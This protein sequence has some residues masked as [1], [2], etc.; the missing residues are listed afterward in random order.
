MVHMSQRDGTQHPAAATGLNK[1]ARLVP[2]K[3][4]PRMRQ[5]VSRHV[6]RRGA[7][8]HALRYCQQNPGK[9]RGLASMGNV[10]D[11]VKPVTSALQTL[12]GIESETRALILAEAPS[13]LLSE[14]AAEIEK[15]GATSIGEIEKLIGDMQEAKN[16]LQS[17]GERIQRETARYTKLAQTASASIE[18]IFD[19]V[20]GWR[21][22]GHPV[23]NQ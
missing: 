1:T 20:R 2:D 13:K 5:N 11:G 21:E 19:T 6:A 9:G 12:A 4:Y 22:A 17:E 16:F 15:I 14:T 10:M 8:R 7:V 18:I 3:I 23:D